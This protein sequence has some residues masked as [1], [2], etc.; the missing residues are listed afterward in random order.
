MRTSCSRY[1]TFMNR[2]IVHIHTVL[3]PPELKHITSTRDMI[4]CHVQKKRYSGITYVSCM[5]VFYNLC[6]RFVI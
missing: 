1:L 4:T 5:P 3:M 6:L 2:S